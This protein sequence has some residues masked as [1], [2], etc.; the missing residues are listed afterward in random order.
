[1]DQVAF[2]VRNVK[3]TAFGV[4]IVTLQAG[5]GIPVGHR[6]YFGARARQ[7]GKKRELFGKMNGL[8][9]KLQGETSAKKQ[10]CQSFHK[11]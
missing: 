8:R 6:R 3:T 4:K 7:I 9:R 1:M 10:G 2:L 5:E 11:W